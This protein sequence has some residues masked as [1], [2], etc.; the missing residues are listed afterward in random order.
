MFPS[1]TEFLAKLIELKI[2]LASMSIHGHFSVLDASFA[3]ASTDRP[4]PR[5][6][7]CSLL[8]CG[9][10]RLALRVTNDSHIHQDTWEP[11]E[12]AGATHEG[13][14][15]PL[16]YPFSQLKGFFWDSSVH[17]ESDHESEIIQVSTE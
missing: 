3:R 1:S 14:F 4:Y 9:H 12:F 11:S 7:S 6:G 2:F 8:L 17:H 5:A 15:H 10:I 16:S 13:I